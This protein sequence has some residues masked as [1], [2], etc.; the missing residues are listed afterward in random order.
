MLNKMKREYEVVSPYPSEH[1]ST[2]HFIDLRQA[3]SDLS[4]INLGH[5]ATEVL[6]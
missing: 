4:R 6:Y 5:A 3:A 2:G 1:I